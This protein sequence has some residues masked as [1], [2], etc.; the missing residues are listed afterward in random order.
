MMQN[1]ASGRP[2]HIAAI[3]LVCL[4]LLSSCVFG[5]SG[6]TGTST[7][8]KV[9]AGSPSA[10][11][12][13]PSPTAVGLASLLQTEQLL[14][15]T[16]HPLRDLYSLARRLKLHT[17]API[18]HVGRTTPLN[19]QV[20]Q[21]DMFWI[22]NS[23]TRAYARIRAQLV[24]ITPHVYMYVED[25][26]HVDLAAL[27]LSANLFEQSTYVTDRA[28]YGSEWS[29]GIDDDVHLTI[30]NAVGLGSGV[31]GYFS[32]EDEYPTIINPYSNER[33]MFYVSLD[34][35]ETPGTPDYNSTLAHEFQHMIH[36][37]QHPVDLSW[38]NE[39]MSVLAQ[40][41]NGFSA[42][43]LD[44][45]F[46]QK[47]DTQLNDWSDDINADLEHYGA[48]Y[49]FMDYFAE[50][51]GGYGVLKELLQDPTSPPVNF[52]DVLAK[53]GYTDRF[54]DVLEKWYVA[55][56]VED[57]TIGQ[58][59]YGYP[60]IHLPGV[61]PQHTIQSYPTS[62]ADTVHQYAAEYYAVQ[63]SGKSGTLSISLRGAPTVRI[64][65]NNPT[66]SSQEWWSNRYDNMDSTLTRSFD[67]TSLAGKSVSLKFS[68]WFD[69]EPQYDYVFVE[70]STDGLNWTTLKGNYTTTSN[71][72][73][74]NWGN[75]YTGESGG[76]AAPQWVQEHMD[77]TPYAGK[78]IQLRFE[79]VTDDAVNYQGFAIDQI[80][81]PALGFQDAVTSDN[82][83]VSTGFIRSNN[84]LPE[85][86]SLQA[87]VYQGSSFTLQTM[88]VDLASGT[89]TLSIP[90]FGS[91]VTRVV[92]VVSAYAAETTL[93]AQ[94]R[95]NVNVT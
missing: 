22:N 78:K 72:N 52:D 42:G 11:G 10:G 53:H 94:Y 90:N 5:G 31:G 55:N 4:V 26:Q 45:D 43:G 39:G 88:R 80:S 18:P 63:P 8:T 81:I 54:F 25:G 70:V 16:P 19:E 74:A 9:V 82:G 36:W 14:L 67:L 27:E 13:L 37:Y 20:G 65:G 89:G 3:L 93:L 77:L 60:T 50:H 66:G 33:E 6:P 35:G 87:L 29:P 2:G 61:T 75:G 47:P 32:S 71:P 38:T 46:V 92:L 49:L 69:L 7:P 44:Q 28:T 40:H 58:G 91:Q 1:K 57:S 84:I 24:Y 30:L 17:P 12:N 21:E 62:E 41:I 51:Y 59:Q 34:G 64:V 56:Y 73:G 48:G 85:H 79:E 68:T 86:F 15:M 23:D 76:G 95:L 83:W